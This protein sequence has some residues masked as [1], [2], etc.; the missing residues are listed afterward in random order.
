MGLRV[1]PSLQWMFQPDQKRNHFSRAAAPEIISVSSVVM[2]ACRD[3]H[4][5]KHHVHTH[6]NSSDTNLAHTL[7]SALQSGCRCI[8]NHA[9][10]RMQD[11]LSRRDVISEMPSM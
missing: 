7:S 10:K 1:S 11:M 9:C 8:G 6:Q 2:A 3:L 4:A 5:D